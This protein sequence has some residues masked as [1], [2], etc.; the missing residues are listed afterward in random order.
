MS[1]LESLRSASSLSDL[2]ILLGFRPSAVSYI[3]YKRTPTE[4]YRAF[5]VP[6]KRG[7]YRTIHAPVEGLKTLQRR[8]S[9]LLQDCLDEI[10]QSNVDRISHG[11]VRKKSIVTNASQHYRRRWVFNI[12]LE[13]FFPSINFG[14]VRGFL[15]KNRDFAV[16]ERVATV[17]AQI[18]CHDNSLPQGSPCSPVFSNLIGHLMDIRLVRL[19][20]EAAC[21][22]SRYADDLTFSTNRAKFPSEIATLSQKNATGPQV[23]EPSALLRDA[24]DRSG[25]RI[26]AS[27]TRLMYR[28]SRQEV[29]GL[30]VNAKVNVR[31]E[32]R[33]NVRAMVHRLTTTGEF[34]IRRMTRSNGGMVLEERKGRLNELH[35][36][37]GFIDSI[38]RHRKVGDQ[39]RSSEDE[40]GKSSEKD[41]KRAK[42]KPYRDF[43]MYSAFHAAERPVVL[44]EGKTDNV[45]MTHAIRSLATEF[46]ELA[47]VDANNRVCIKV[48]LYRYT[49]SATGRIL[50]MRSGGDGALAGF[51]ASYRKITRGFAQKPG[52]SPVIIV[53]DNDDGAKSIRKTIKSAYKV[54]ATESAFCHV[55]GNLY[56]VPTPGTGSKIE[57]LFDDS[58][59]AMTI[60]GKS[61]D[62]NAKDD[63]SQEHYGKTV[64]AH[65][66]VAAHASR[67][68]FS[69]FR[70]LLTQIVGAIRHFRDFER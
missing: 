5:A 57:D 32:Y 65:K 38:D 63:Q 31:R 62:A 20:S 21:Y 8:L 60:G 52:R 14:R 3:L 67:I 11:F 19:A 47:D 59:K 4:N 54:T 9:V 66:V 13:D 37:L 28:F 56:A 41:R 35:G 48:R 45:Y 55:Y 51:I 2:A 10:Q 70:P 24:I 53:Y 34:T 26:N 50:R 12:D 17:M 7:G 36:M 40:K 29:T 68:D 46:P 30:V 1:R 16:H 42:E 44:C 15:M 43:L 58:V 49:Q 22:Y 23:W 6:K 64:F 69:K 61:F 18:A 33:R 25:F 27:K 39:R